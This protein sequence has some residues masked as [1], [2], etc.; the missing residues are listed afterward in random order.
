M[1]AP[2]ECRGAKQKHKSEGGWGVGG[3]ELATCNESN[4]K[5]KSL[6]Y[7]LLSLSRGAG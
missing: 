2:L 6:K 7:Q 5:G 4:M 1:A 3:G